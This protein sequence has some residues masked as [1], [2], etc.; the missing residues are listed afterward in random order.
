[1]NCGSILYAVHDG[2]WVLRLRGDVRA[3]WCASLDAVVERIFADPGLKG[4]FVDLREATNIDSTMLG[5]LARVA[6]RSRDELKK[7]PVLVGPN[8]DVRRLLDSMCF[9]KVFVIADDAAEAR[10]DCAEV[11]VVDRPES[12]L[13]RQVTEAHRVLMDIDERNRATFRDVV[14]TLEDQQRAAGR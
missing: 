8:P 10:C 3:N 4:V 11:P 5:L 7:A 1:M 13:C 6:I 2:K 9:E 12:E 14:A